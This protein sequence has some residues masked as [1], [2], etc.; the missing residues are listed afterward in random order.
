MFCMFGTYSCFEKA[1]YV[2]PNTVSSAELLGL[3]IIVFRSNR[4]N[5]SQKIL[6]LLL[7]IFIF[8]TWP[9]L[10]SECDWQLFYS[11]NTDHSS[12]CMY[13][14]NQQILWHF[15]SYGS[16]IEE[17]DLMVRSVFHSSTL[18]ELFKLRTPITYTMFTMWS[19]KHSSILVISH[20]NYIF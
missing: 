9:E 10:L 11:T 15:K 7:V 18:W 19:S 6:Q 1:Q 13:V 5:W 3:S 2:F 4:W 20:L 16:L 14:P 12:C 17:P 8:A